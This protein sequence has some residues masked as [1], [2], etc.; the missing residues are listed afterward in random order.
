MVNQT[1]VNLNDIQSVTATSAPRA[2]EPPQAPQTVAT[3][4]DLN[5]EPTRGNFP[6]ATAFREL[7]GRINFNRVLKMVQGK[8]VTANHGN[9]TF[10]RVIPSDLNYHSPTAITEVKEYLKA[11]GYSITEIE[12]TAGNP[13]GWRLSW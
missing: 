12:D 7:C 1:N 10:V 6:T 13:N 2:A 8:M 5:A 11:Q 4:F 9:E 3:E